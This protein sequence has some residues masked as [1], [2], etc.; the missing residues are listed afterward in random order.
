M[1]TAVESTLADSA[2]VGSINSMARSQ[3]GTAIAAW[4]CQTDLLEDE[5]GFRGAILAPETLQMI[6]LPRFW[7][8]YKE[9]ILV[10]SGVAMAVL[11]MFLIAA[12]LITRF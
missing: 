8:K 11:G 5:E 6:E 2:S 4:S 7:T 12:C 1:K 3:A 9:D 10:T